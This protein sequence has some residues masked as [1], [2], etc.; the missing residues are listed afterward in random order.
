MTGGRIAVIFVAVSVLGTSGVALATVPPVESVDTSSITAQRAGDVSLVDAD[1][2]GAVLSKGGSTTEFSLSLPGKATCPGD[3][4]NDNWRVQTFIVPADV[5]PGSIQYGPNGPTGT[6]QW[7]FHDTVT[8]PVIEGLLVPNEQPGAEAR[9]D[10]FPPMSF[11]V[12]PVGEI[13]PG[14]YRAG[15]A[16]TWFGATGPY[17]DTEMVFADDPSDEPGRLSW[18]VPGAAEA[19]GGGSSSSSSS[20]PWSTIFVLIA[21]LAFGFAFFLGRKPGQPKRSIR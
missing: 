5:D 3:S 18:V 21:V 13:P 16:C 17:W 12:F 14:S 1:R 9:V 4:R 19:A 15:A 6:H 10:T 11:R 8:S 20:P 7:A 2:R